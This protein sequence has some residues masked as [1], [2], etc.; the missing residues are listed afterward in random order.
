MV[1]GFSAIKIPFCLEHSVEQAAWE[2]FQPEVVNH[3]ARLSNCAT[4]LPVRPRQCPRTPSCRARVAPVGSPVQCAAPLPGATAHARSPFHCPWSSAARQASVGGAENQALTARS[5]SLVAGRVAHTSA[6]VQRWT[7]AG[8][9][10]WS[11][12]STASATG[13][14]WLSTHLPRCLDDHVQGK[15]RAVDRAVASRQSPVF[16]GRPK[17][18]DRRR[19]RDG[20]RLGRLRPDGAEMT[21]QI[22]G[23]AADQAL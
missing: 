16:S 6:S 12:I 22:P 7:A 17:T 1:R 3:A 15:R 18:G 10:R 11:S 8:R 9:S 19:L 2:G 23:T 5:A 14:R 13:W 4:G 21:R 20:R